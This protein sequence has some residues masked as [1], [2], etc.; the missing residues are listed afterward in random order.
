MNCSPVGGGENPECSR[1][2]Y[3]IL[4]DFEAVPVRIKEE[5]VPVEVSKATR[6]TLRSKRPINV[7][8]PHRRREEDSFDH[9]ISPHTDLI[10]RELAF[11]ASKARKRAMAFHFNELYEITK[12]L[13]YH[14]YEDSGLPGRVHEHKSQLLTQLSSHLYEKFGT[15]RTKRQI[16][17]R[18]SDLKSREPKTFMKIKN[19]ILKEVSLRKVSDSESEVSEDE[20][21]SEVNISMTSAEIQDALVSSYIQ[22]DDMQVTQSCQNHI[23]REDVLNLLPLSYTSNEGYSSVGEAHT[24]EEGGSRIEKIEQSLHSLQAKMDQLLSSLSG[25]RDSS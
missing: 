25:R 2:D 10:K 1:D 24:E 6:P 4:K 3:Q 15:T 13:L 18:Y 5:E 20:M 17:K 11:S 16:Q 14:G 9:E 21:Q 8:I 7:H 19:R 22:A 23:V 12:Y